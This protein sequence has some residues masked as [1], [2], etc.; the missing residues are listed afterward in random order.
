MPD[1]DLVG[2]YVEES[3]EELLTAAGEP[4]LQPQ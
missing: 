4:V 2:A 1:I 3:L